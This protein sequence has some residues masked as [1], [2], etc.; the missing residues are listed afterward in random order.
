MIAMEESA[1]EIRAK[2]YRET[3]AAIRARAVSSDFAAVRADLCSLA[4]DYEL[5]ADLVQSSPD[6]T[7]ALDDLWSSLKHPRRGNGDAAR[8]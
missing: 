4:T 2:Y 8:K 3:A 6:S 7:E 1:R 5:L